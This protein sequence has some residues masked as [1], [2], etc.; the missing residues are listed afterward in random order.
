MGI[1]SMAFLALI[2][3]TILDTVT[4]GRRELRMLSYLQHPAVLP[5]NEAAH[6]AQSASWTTDTGRK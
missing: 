1:I 6:V 5:G 3:G 4:G 2:T